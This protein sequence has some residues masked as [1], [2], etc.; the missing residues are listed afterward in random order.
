MKVLLTKDVKGVG[1]TGEIKDVADGYG[2]NFLI[3]KG[4]AFAATHE[5]LK[6]YESDQRKKAANEAA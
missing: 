2:K 4:L 6:K 5:V 3:G 1:K